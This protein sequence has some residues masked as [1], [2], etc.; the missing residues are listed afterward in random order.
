MTNLWFTYNETDDFFYILMHD[1]GSGRMP[2]DIVVSSTTAE[3]LCMSCQYANFQPFT[4][5]IYETV[6]KLQK[7]PNK[8]ILVVVENEI[9][10]A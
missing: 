5:M 4:R 10:D 7:V 8:S 2:E 6:Q 3:T 1:P 9:T